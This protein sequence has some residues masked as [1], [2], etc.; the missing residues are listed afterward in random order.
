[1]KR[2]AHPL[3]KISKLWFVLLPIF[4]F[5]H[6]LKLVGYMFL[7]LSLHECGHLLAAKLTHYKVK[8]LIVYPF[9][10]S[11]EIA[12]MGHG[13]VYREL[14]ILIAGPLVHLFIP[15]LLSV[16]LK[17]N[18]I[19]SSYFE[20]LLKINRSMLLFNLLPIYP[21]DGGRIMQSLLHI[22]FRYQR[23]QRLTF[24]CSVC[25]IFVVLKFRLLQGMSGIVVLFFLALQILQGFKQRKQDV[26]QF[27]YYRSNHP[28]LGKIR[29]NTSLDLFRGFT[30]LL[31]RNKSWVLENEYLKRL[32]EISYSK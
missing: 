29:Y 17:M 27:L 32:F 8:Q 28:Y 2:Q 23:A 4:Y 12:H 20:Y 25:M 11:A 22:C 13:N 16:C 5:A 24:I 30:N 18:L 6:M 21:L 10:C 3:F 26:V 31:Y 19:S 1:M 9:G 15:L 14:C 7:I